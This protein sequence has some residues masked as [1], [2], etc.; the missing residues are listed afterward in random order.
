MAANMVA[1]HF[2]ATSR[3]YYKN[4]IIRNKSIGS[5]WLEEMQNTWIG[6]GIIHWRL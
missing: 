3:F 2:I 5:A 1:P 4:T 6:R